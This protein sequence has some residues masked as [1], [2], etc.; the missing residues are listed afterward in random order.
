MDGLEP[1]RLPPSPFSYRR[2]RSVSSA[3]RNIGLRAPGRTTRSPAAASVSSGG[4]LRRKLLP[5]RHQLRKPSDGCSSILDTMRPEVPASA[6]S[7]LQPAR[8]V[9]KPLRVE[10][11]FLNP[12][13]PFITGQRQSSHVLLQLLRS[14]GELGMGL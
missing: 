5:C 7:R 6:S 1:H 4:S 14:P 11:D 8:R 3:C 13:V 2:A 10:L 12:D 9:Y